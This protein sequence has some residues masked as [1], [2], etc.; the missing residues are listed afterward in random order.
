MT[1]KQQME[2]SKWSTPLISRT[3]HVCKR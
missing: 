2:I 1:L 3:A